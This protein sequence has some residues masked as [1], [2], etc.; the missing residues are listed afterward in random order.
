MVNMSFDL[1][2]FD[3]LSIHW[4]YKNGKQLMKRNT[5]IIVNWVLKLKIIRIGLLDSGWSILNEFGGLRHV[6]VK[7]WNTIL[8]IQRQRK[9]K[10]NHKLSNSIMVMTPK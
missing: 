3:I 2:C 1:G 5:R 9:K 10:L 8:Q 7:K 4:E 6:R